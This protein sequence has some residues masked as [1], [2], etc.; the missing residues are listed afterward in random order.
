M[1]SDD[2]DPIDHELVSNIL[3]CY[4]STHGSSQVDAGATDE[5]GELWKA[6]LSTLAVFAAA[7]IA[8]DDESFKA[9]A[10]RF[11]GQPKDDSEECAR[12]RLFVLDNFMSEDFRSDAVLSRRVAWARE[13]YLHER[14]SKPL[15]S[16][17][18]H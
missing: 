10:A 12:M 9:M 15:I 3:A 8:K 18:S 17:S 6:A 14:G 1:P 13:A 2:L 4:R 7:G 11:L 5:S 16:S